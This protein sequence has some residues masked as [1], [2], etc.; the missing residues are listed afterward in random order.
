MSF[1]R[2]AAA[3][4]VDGGRARHF[5]VISDIPLSFIARPKGGLFRYHVKRIHFTMQGFGFLS[6]I[7]DEAKLKASYYY[8]GSAAIIQSR[9]I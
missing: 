9:E 1:G 2:I 8:Y 3:R 5:D 4:K 7:F 6:A